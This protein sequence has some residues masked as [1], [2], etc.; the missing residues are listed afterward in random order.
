M[1]RLF[2]LLI[3]CTCLVPNL[4]KAENLCII[5]N[6]T[7]LGTGQDIYTAPD[8]YGLI[9]KHNGLYSSVEGDTLTT[10]NQ[11]DIVWAVQSGITINPIVSLTEK[12]L[13][14]LTVGTAIDLV[15]LG[16][17]TDD[18]IFLEGI[19]G[20]YLYQEEYPNQYIRFTVSE[21]DTYTLITGDNVG[22]MVT[23]VSNYVNFHSMV[24][25]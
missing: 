5:P 2:L 24:M 17:E 7:Y 9:W 21:N 11:F 6:I 22:L 12:D 18:G 15:I 13:G 10:V 3:I 19:K 14:Y 16:D 20:N 4:V 1:K 8:G 25:K 23:C